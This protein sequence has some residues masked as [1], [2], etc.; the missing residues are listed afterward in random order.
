EWGRSIGQGAV[1]PA[2][3]RPAGVERN[4]VIT[5]WAWGDRYTYAHDEI[6]TDKRD[7]HVNAG[8]PV[9][10]V[11]LA[12]DYLLVVDPRTHTA[13]RI[14]VPTRNG[15]A[16]KLLTLVLPWATKEQM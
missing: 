15:F 2:P 10:G 9:Y 11:D 13:D 1:P 12:N 5:Q 16:T 3:A 4:I 6:A 8:G 14:K 7:P